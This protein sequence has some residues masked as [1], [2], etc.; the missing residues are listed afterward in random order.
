MIHPFVADSSTTLT[1]NQGLL[2]AVGSGLFAA[3]FTAVF[4]LGGQWWE[5]RHDRDVREKQMEHDRATAQE[6]ISHDRQE[7]EKAMAHDREMR[8]DAMQHDHDLRLREQRVAA[9]DAFFEAVTRTLVVYTSRD[10]TV[11]LVGSRALLEQDAYRR[12]SA[13]NAHQLEAYTLAARVE[14]AYGPGTAPT[15]AARSLFDELAAFGDTVEALGKALLAHIDAKGSQAEQSAR[16]NYVKAFE[17]R[18]YAYRGLVASQ[19]RFCRE[20]AK[21]D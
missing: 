2:I 15:K 3:V 1:F 13:G 16:N 17:A 8:A 10:P 12:V 11:P 19:E 9:A 7:R 21:G 18:Q 6:Q 4:A 14:L 20:A 5:H